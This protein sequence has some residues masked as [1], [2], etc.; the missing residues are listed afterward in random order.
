MFWH[1]KNM[2]TNKGLPGERLRGAR[3]LG[4]GACVVLA[5]TSVGCGNS[6]DFFGG[7]PPPASKIQAEQGVS[8]LETDWSKV[9]VPPADGPELAPIAFVTPV[10]Q[11]PDTESPAVGY[12]RVGARVARSREPVSKA[13]CPGGWYAVRP[14]GFVCAGP[15]ATLDMSN[16]IA[17]A[18]QVEPNRANPMP[19]KY[20]FVRAIAPNY[21]RVPT[22][23]EQFQY[24]MGLKRHLHAWKR[25]HDKW[26]RLDIGANDVPLDA[27]GVAIGGIPTEPKPMDM[28]VRFGGN[29]DDSVPWWLV[30]ERRIPNISSF[31]APPYAVIANRIKRHAGVALIGSFVAGPEAMN[32]RFAITTDTR[33]I[34]ADKLKPTSG[35]PFHGYDIRDV[36]LPVAFSYRVGATSWRVEDGKLEHG[37]KLAWRQFIPLTGRVQMIRGVRMAETKDGAWVRSEDLKTIA[38]PGSL[39][40]FAK[41][42]VKWIDISIVSQSMVLWDG[43][44]PVYATLVSTGRGGLGEPGKTLSTPRGVFR[45]YQKHV[46]T[47]MDSDVA[48]HE[49]ELRDVPWV[50]YF[51][52]GY[53]IHGAYWHDGFGK[54]RSHG[55]VNVAPID[56]RYVFMWSLPQ[57]PEHWQAAYAVPPF[58]KGTIV[59]IHP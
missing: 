55:C 49:F 10:Y 20:A 48:D 11:K 52:G 32:R 18:I 40:P 2:L 22:R 35:S 56:A 45:I 4:A 42:G 47:T 15:D 16:P 26:D 57:V 41:Q 14:V 46:T 59:D 21:L 1:S 51:K 43:T 33:L 50:M 8:P 28:S 29:D 9:P 58:E 17:R 44:K 12:L 34:P 24:E 13:G 53:A 37:P 19:Y 36:G 27:N 54:V 23:A 38:K 6:V 7:K 25:L 39:P 3:V 31:K 30:G 5:L